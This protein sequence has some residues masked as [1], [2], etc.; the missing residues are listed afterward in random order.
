MAK[1]KGRSERIIGL[2]NPCRKCNSLM[3][4]KEY[5]FLRLIRAL[6]L[7][8]GSIVHRINRTTRINHDLLRCGRLTVRLGI[9]GHDSTLLCWRS[10]SRL[11]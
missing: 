4:A 1:G 7:I 10:Y 5:G 3:G 6:W 8:R 11:A 2:A 9:T